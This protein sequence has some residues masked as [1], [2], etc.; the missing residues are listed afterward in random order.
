MKLLIKDCLSSLQAL[1]EFGKNKY[2]IQVAM[3]VAGNTRALQEIGK[4]YEDRRQELIKTNGKQ[5]A[6]GNFEV[7]KEKS[8]KFTDAMQAMLD[9]EVDPDLKT[10]SIADL[11]GAKVPMEPNVLVAIDWMIT[12]EGQ[13]PSRSKPR[14]VPSK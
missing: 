3:V 5:N 9:E 14:G 2:P 12:M 13:K 7:T 10:V 11:G 6:D 4:E 8:K 1:T